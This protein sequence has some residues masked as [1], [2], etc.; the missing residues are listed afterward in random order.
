MHDYDE[1]LRQMGRLD[2]I[3]AVFRRVG[4]MDSRRMRVC[5]VVLMLL[6]LL[7]P[8]AV[9]AGAAGAGASDSTAMFVIDA[10]L[11]QCTISHVYCAGQNYAAI[12][13]DRRRSFLQ[14]RCVSIN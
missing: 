13:S 2:M 14:T 11:P 12:G 9:A 8:A 4:R 10:V 3:H 6:Q 5:L 1:F 7:T